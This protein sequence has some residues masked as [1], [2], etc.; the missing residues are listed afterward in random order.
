MNSNEYLV[1]LIDDDPLS[2][3]LTTETISF[4]YP[5]DKILSYT[6]PAIGLEKVV[7]NIMS[8]EKIILFLDIN[9]PLISGWDI[10]E[11]LSMLEVD[12]SALKIY[13]LSSSIERADKLKVFAYKNVSGYLEKPLYEIDIEAILTENN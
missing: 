6:D 8:C 5:A 3:L 11:K 12:K 13:M 10:V 7:S 4:Y 2:N 9:M 1:I